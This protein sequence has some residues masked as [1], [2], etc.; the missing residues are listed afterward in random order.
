MFLETSAVRGQPVCE[1]I[2][3]KSCSRFEFGGHAS[4]ILGRTGYR[5]RLQLKVCEFWNFWF[6]RSE[7]PGL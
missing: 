1:G 6:F 7:R 4:R 3:G 2:H 5:F